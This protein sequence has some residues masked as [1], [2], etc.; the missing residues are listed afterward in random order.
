MIEKIFK[1]N[2][3][4]SGTAIGKLFIIKDTEVK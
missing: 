3:V 1:G 4:S 2:A